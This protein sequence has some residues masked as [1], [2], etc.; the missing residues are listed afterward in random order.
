MKKDTKAVR[1]SALNIK[2]ANTG[3]RIALGLFM[4]EYRAA[5][6]VYVEYLWSNRIE[7]GDNQILDISNELL[8]VPVFISTTDIPIETKLS[9]RSLKCASTQ[10]CGIVAAVIDKRNKDIN[11]AKWMMQKGYNVPY[12]LKQ[13]LSSPMTKPS[14]MN[15]NAEVNS[16]VVGINDSRV[17]HF[18]L[19]LDM[20]SMFQP[21]VYGRGFNFVIPLKKHRQYKKWEDHKRLNSYLLNEN[22]VVVRFEVQKPT[23]IVGTTIAI[24][25]GQVTCL[26]SSDGQTSLKCNHGHD[27]KSITEKMARQKWGSKANKRTA[28]HRQNYVNWSV[29]QLNL[30]SVGELKLEKISNI[31]Y[32]K[33]ASREMKHWTNTLIRD[34][35]SKRCWERGVLFT[36]VPNEFNSQRCSCCGWTQK[37]NRVKKQFS[38]RKCSHKCDADFNASQNILIRDSLTDLPLGFRKLGYN[39]NGFYWLPDGLFLGSGVAITVPHYQ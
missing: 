6:K 3:K 37:A 33:N 19:W 23:Q 38:C 22:Q 12:Q 9:G 35:L 29:A 10:A 8:D 1:A 24:D 36:E 7:W 32:G 27:L 39:I 34:S 4:K 16:I 18:N 25:Q 26:T 5:V 28:D 17:K 30:D 11:K 13:R 21:E 2:F 20:H 31:N 14:C 15:I